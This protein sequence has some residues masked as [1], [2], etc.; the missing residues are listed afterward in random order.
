LAGAPAAVLTKM[1]MRAARGAGKVAGGG[2][3]GRTNSSCVGAGVCP[4]AQRDFNYADGP[5][6]AAVFGTGHFR[7]DGGPINLE[8]DSGRVFVSPGFNYRRRLA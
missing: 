7:L 2:A 6:G 3:N 1:S 8:V 4:G 5:L